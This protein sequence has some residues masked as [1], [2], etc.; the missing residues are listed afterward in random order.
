M[1]VVMNLEDVGMAQ[2]SNGSSFLFKAA[3]KL[4]PF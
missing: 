4:R 2:T 1:I 3:N